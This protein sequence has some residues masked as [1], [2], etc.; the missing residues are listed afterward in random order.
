MTFSPMRAAILHGKEDLRVE[1][2]VPRPLQPG[3]VRVA[4]HAALTCGTDLKVYARGYHARMG[5]P[6]FPF[7]HEWSG[8]VSEVAPDVPG[9]VPGDRVVGANSAPCGS[10]PPCLRHQ[11]SLCDHLVFLNGA[12]AESIVVPAVLV[13][14]NL[15]RI[16]GHLGWA[17]AALV[18]PLA[19]VVQGVEDVGIGRGDRV[20]VLGA[21]PIGLMAVALA[22]HA[23]AEVTVV[24]RGAVRLGQARRLGAVEALDNA[25]PD[26]I[27][28]ARGAEGTFDVVFEAMGRP[29]AWE[30]ALRFVRKGGRVNWFGGCPTGTSVQVDTVRMH[31]DALTLRASFHH[32]PR[33]I[34]RALDLVA[35][36][37]VTADVF[38]DGRC[39]LSGLPALFRDMT[40]GNRAVKTLVDVRA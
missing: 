1:E 16:P 13:Q 39:P 20:L 19:C 21:G 32:T 40:S 37:V 24:G 33:T 8:V 38:V 18:E 30:A 6:P 2:V 35:A 15:L 28:A 12:Y 10:C 23:G 25:A 7:G 36:G 17:D 26:R 4:I 9:W 27:E 22:R 31:Y 3:E 11:E 29:F 5:V 14:R 34:R